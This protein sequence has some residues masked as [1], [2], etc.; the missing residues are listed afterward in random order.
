MTARA[1]G[2]RFSTCYALMM[3][4][5]GVQLPFLPLWLHAKGLSVSHIAA[6][7]AAMM[8][9]RVI[10]APLFAYIADRSGNRLM[11]IRSCAVSALIAYMALPLTD[12][13]AQILTVAL[14]A[15]LLFAPVFPLTEGFSV[16]AS[17][18]HGLDYGRLR[19]WA[20]ISFLSGSLISGALLTRLPAESTAWLIAAA[21]S[22][23]VL[24]TFLLPADPKRNGDHHHASAMEFG[25]ALKFLFAS[26]FTV[27]LLGACLANASHAMLYSFSS[28][29]WTGLGYGTMTIGIL[30]ACSVSAEVGLFAFSNAVIERLGPPL[31]LCIGLVGGLVRWMGMAYASGVVE[32][33]VL[34]MLHAVSFASAHLAL[35]HFIRLNVPS[36]LRNT[37]QGLY[38]AVAG[39]VLLSSVTW[40]S[41]PLYQRFGGEAYLAMAMISAV[42]LGFA[43]TYL[44]LSP[45]VPVAVAA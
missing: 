30:W 7:V 28:V 4:G 37:A 18:F 16:D 42:G 24:A 32:M 45:K 31:L 13:F 21:Q 2:I 25:A 11:V 8:A 19:L 27:F 39:G 29:H 40:L 14:I 10:G 35:M 34:Q 36:T 20:S 12:G 23:S 5:S 15:G 44:K 22:L 43:V 33:G 38:A 41:G 6:V 9:V 17:A 3:M 1:F 26:R